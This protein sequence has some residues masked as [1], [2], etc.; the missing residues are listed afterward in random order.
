MALALIYH[1]KLDNSTRL[2]RTNNQKNQTSI[3][4]PGDLVLRYVIQPPTEC[5]KL[6]RSWI[7]IYVILEKLD[8]NAYTVAREDDKR[9]KC[10]VHRDRLRLI[11]LPDNKKTSTGSYVSENYDENKKLQ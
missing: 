5:A 7:V 1:Y 8:V 2:R 11:G 3:L 6:Y 10:I 9:E 4:K